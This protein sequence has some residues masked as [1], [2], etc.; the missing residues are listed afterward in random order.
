MITINGKKYAK[1][2]AEFTESLFASD[3]TCVGFYALRKNGV[4]LSDMQNKPFAM[5]VERGYST[6]FVSASRREDGR[7]WYMFALSSADE[8]TLGMDGMRYLDQLDLARSVITSA[9][10]KVA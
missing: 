5:A 2:Q 1:N 7:M 4:L 3:G 6:W 9:R 10:G 8:K